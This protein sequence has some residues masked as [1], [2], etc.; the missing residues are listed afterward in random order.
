MVTVVL[1]ALST[2]IPGYSRSNDSRVCHRYSALANRINRTSL[3]SLSVEFLVKI[4]LC[5]IHDTYLQI[6]SQ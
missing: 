3:W 4:D 5:F 1:F 2:G 6:T